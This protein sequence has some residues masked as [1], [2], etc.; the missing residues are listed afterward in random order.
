VTWAKA[1]YNSIRGKIA[2]RWKR[3]GSKFTLDVTIPANTTAMVFVP[4]R[5]ADAV[6]ESGRLAALN[7]GVVLLWMENGCA[8]FAV[9]SGR[10][11][12]ESKL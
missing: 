10:Y 5:S 12:F 8:V 11:E 2:S 9:E 6:T 1:N 4:A 3:D 7:D